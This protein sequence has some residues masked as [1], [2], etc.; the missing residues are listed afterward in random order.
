MEKK[1][2]PSVNGPVGIGEFCWSKD[3]YVVRTLLL[4]KPWTDASQ[5]GRQTASHQKCPFHRI[6]SEVLPF[7]V[8]QTTT[9]VAFG[10]NANTSK[11][12]EGPTQHL[13]VG[14]SGSV[15]CPA[16]TWLAQA[17]RQ[18]GPAGQPAM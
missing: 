15:F 6:T 11:Q 3:A 18:Q 1:S 8:L 9:A 2:L 10:Q 14:S 12:G 17:L 16:W 5:V 13:R 7:Q 4:C